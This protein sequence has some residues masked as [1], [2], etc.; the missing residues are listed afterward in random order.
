MGMPPHFRLS[1]GSHS[2]PMG[3]ERGRGQRTKDKGA[4]GKGQ[5]GNDWKRNN[6]QTKDTKPFFSGKENLGKGEKV[7]GKK[8]L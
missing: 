6:P 4:E 2:T 1:M 5:R 8:Y 7:K 3:Q